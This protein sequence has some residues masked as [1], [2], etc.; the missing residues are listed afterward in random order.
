M[1]I[2][3][4]TWPASEDAVE[5]VHVDSWLEADT[6]LARSREDGADRRALCNGCIVPAIALGQHAAVWCDA[7]E[8]CERCAAR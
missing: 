4:V 3:V 2:C 8:R 7:H 6:L 1:A 5:H